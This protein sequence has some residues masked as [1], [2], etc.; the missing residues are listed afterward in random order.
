VVGD[1]AVG[2][3]SRPS[4]ETALFYEVQKPQKSPR[5]RTIGFSP[6]APTSLT[7]LD[8]SVATQTPSPAFRAL[9]GDFARFCQ[10]NHFRL[11]SAALP[12]DPLGRLHE[13]GADAHPLKRRQHAHGPQEGASFV[14]PL[15]EI[16]PRLSDRKPVGLGHQHDI[17][18]VL[19]LAS[20]GRMDD[21]PVLGK[22]TEPFE[23]GQ[24][25]PDA[26]PDRDVYVRAKLLE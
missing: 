13:A 3:M 5:P 17:I 26:G 16:D 22:E 18:A 11:R 10:P 2:G 8:R 24:I 25:L 20:E 6:A 9:E 4:H 1:G 12:H 21:L 14:A 19:L 15:D 23:V 7:G